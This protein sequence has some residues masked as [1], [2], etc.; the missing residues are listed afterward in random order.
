MATTSIFV[1]MFS[2]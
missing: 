2:S 1:K